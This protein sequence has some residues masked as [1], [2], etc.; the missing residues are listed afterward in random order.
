V[1]QLYHQSLQCEHIYFFR[2]P[3]L[4]LELPPNYGHTP[5]NAV[6]ISPMYS[7]TYVHNAHNILNTF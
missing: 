5:L 4:L 7:Y 3:Q 6:S 2:R 1:R